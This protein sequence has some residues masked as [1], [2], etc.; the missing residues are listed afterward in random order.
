V[1]LFLIP[2]AVLVGAGGF[3]GW[4]LHAQAAERQDGLRMA[5]AGNFTEAEPLLRGAVER[6]PGDVEAVRVLAVGYL[7]A[8]RFEE[9]QPY[10]DR[11]CE[12]QPDRAE[13]LERRIELWRRLG[14]MGKSVDDV[15]RVLEIE[16]GHE[17]YRLQ[18]P[19][20]LL[21][22]GRLDEADQECQRS[23]QVLRGNRWLLVL[24]AT[25]DQRKGR[26]AAATQLADRLLQQ[27]PR[28]EDVLILR[29][30]IYLDADQPEKAVP[31]LRK[32]RELPDQLQQAK[33][34]YTLS[35]ALSRTGQAEEAE[36]MMAEARALQELDLLAKNHKN[37]DNPELQLRVAG[38][39]MQAGRRKEAYPLLAAVVKADPSN[40]AAHRLLATYY[41]KE[42]QPGPAAEHRRRAGQTP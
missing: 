34:A 1:W 9:A 7:N 26:T 31:L 24:K 4:R 17:R 10:L 39:L 12:L 23:L 6:D 37:R 11:W 21:M 29:A 27:Y 35:L 20:L 13:P 41:E 36:R 42:G 5:E 38:S 25:V 15:K 30:S 19:R 16:P 8:E 18:L 28:W 2:L 33:T 22:T 40:A 3:F 32:A 14:R